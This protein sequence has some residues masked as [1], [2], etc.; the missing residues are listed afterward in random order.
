MIT[1]AE[2]LAMTVEDRGRLIF[3]L[4]ALVRT[5]L[6]R[7]GLHRNGRARARLD[8]LFWHAHVLVWGLDRLTVSNRAREAI[9]RQH[10]NL[11]GDTPVWAKRV[12]DGGLDAYALYLAKAPLKHYRMHPTKGEKVDQETVPTKTAV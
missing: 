11:L 8:G 4:Q 12:K 7:N 2:A 10:R 1:M 3:R 6:K 5:A 9:G